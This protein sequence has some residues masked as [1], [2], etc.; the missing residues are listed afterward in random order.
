MSS[1]LRLTLLGVMALLVALMWGM[2]FVSQRFERVASG[3]AALD[4]REFDALALVTVGTG[5]TFENPWRLGPSIAVARGTGIWL[6]DAGRGVAEALRAAEIPAHQP[7]VVLLTS[8]LPENTVGLDDLW[9]DGWLGPREAPLRV[10]GPAGTGSLVQGLLAA[11]ARGRALQQGEWALPDAGGRIEVTELAGGEA[12]ALEGAR[13]RVASLEGGPFP[14]LAYRFEAGER[15][16]AVA[17][18]G[19]DP[20]AIARLAQDA[21]LLAVGAVYGASLEAAADAQ[22]DRLDVL[23]REARHH[24]R[25]EDAGALARRA[26]VGKLVLVRLRPPPVFDFQYE[27]LVGAGFRGP[28]VVASDGDVITP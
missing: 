5:G 8:L 1:G 15:S 17:T 16:V 12:L 7:R 14:A 4:E 22:V 25:L 3:V 9:L 6:V 19:F 28:V 26:G 21:D 27:R 13:V 20:D 24:L 23:Q 10:F 11:H 2:A 18:L